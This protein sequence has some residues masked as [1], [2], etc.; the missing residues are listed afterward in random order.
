MNTSRPKNSFAGVAALA[1]IALLGG[2]GFCEEATYAAAFCAPAP[3]SGCATSG[4]SRL[5]I[6]DPKGNSRDSIS[7]RFMR[8]T[9]APTL[10]AFGNPLTGTSLAICIYD[11]D[12]LKID[13]QVPP[14]ATKWQ[15]AGRMTS[16]QYFDKDGSEDGIKRVLLRSGPDGRVRIVVRSRGSNV[17]LPAP[18]SSETYFNQTVSV[19]VQL[20]N[21]SG[22]C[23]QA[24]LAPADTVVNHLRRFKSLF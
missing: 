6:T 5:T 9:G 1:V 22:A 4:R 19:V 24:T 18:A 12:V 17:P 3:V 20:R 8:G 2:F 13:T 21:D 14:S 11:D 16:Y 23:W 10:A 7:W 15:E